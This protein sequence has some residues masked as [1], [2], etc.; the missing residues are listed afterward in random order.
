MNKLNES[1][2]KIEQLLDLNIEELLDLLPNNIC[3]GE[4]HK[5]QPMGFLEITKCID[6]SFHICYIDHNNNQTRKEATRLF[7]VS[8]CKS[9]KL[10]LIETYFRVEALL[11][12]HKHNSA[13]VKVMTTEEEK[14]K[15]LFSA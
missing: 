3:L 7:E 13:A 10:G 1:L 6:N 9:L 12:K 4:G 5:L 8:Y 14:T 2:N 15:E 11:E